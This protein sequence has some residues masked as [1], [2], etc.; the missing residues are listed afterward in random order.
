VRNINREQWRALPPGS[1][2]TVHLDSENCSSRCSGTADDHP[3][4]NLCSMHTIWI[5]CTSRCTC[6][7]VTVYKSCY[8]DNHEIL[9][10]ICLLHNESTNICNHFRLHSLDGVHKCGLLLH[11]SHVVWS[12]CLFV[13]TW[14]SC[15]K[16]AETIEMSFR[17]LT[18]VGSRNHVLDGVHCATQW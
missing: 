5:P 8:I 15:A 9:L 17:G 4:S 1:P 16:T 18:H 12:V 10:T 6:M 11:M 13:G 14:V 2:A 7:L 3:C